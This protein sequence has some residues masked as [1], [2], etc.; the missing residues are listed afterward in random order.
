MYKVDE[1]I[2]VEFIIVSN[3]SC[4]KLDKY[5]AQFINEYLLLPISLFL[6]NECEGNKVILILASID[7]NY[8]DF[9]K[10]SNLEVI[11]FSKIQTCVADAII[12]VN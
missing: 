5:D 9:I 6:V 11:D 12:D 8:Y 3:Y 7:I 1:A 4:V 10:Y 2:L